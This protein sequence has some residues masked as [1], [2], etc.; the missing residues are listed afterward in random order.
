LYLSIHAKLRIGVEVEHQSSVGA[1]YVSGLVDAVQRAGVDRVELMRHAG[2]AADAHHA[3]VRMPM[4]DVI[5]LFQ[6]AVALTGRSDI[7]LEFARHVRP[8]TFNVLGYALMTCKTLGEAIAL[9]PHYRRLV[10][11][12]GY[13]EM[14]LVSTHDEVRLGWH[15]VSR[16]LPYC[17]SL[18]ES[19]IA[20][21]YQFGR[22]I[23]GV[24]LPL[25]EVRFLHSAPRD[26]R[27]YSEFFE[28]P[29]HFNARENALVFSRL[30]LDMPLV[31]ADETLHL[32]M[33]AQAQAAMEKTFSESD[34][35][36]RLRKA[37]I[38]LMPQCEATLEKAA[39]MLH[40]SPRSLQRRL[41]DVSLGFQGILD[42][43][44]RDM[45][46]IYLRDPGLSALD[47]ALLLGYAEQSSFTRAF[48]TWFG[49]NPRA[50][51][52]G[53]LQRSPSDSGALNIDLATSP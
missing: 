41:G 28:C 17:S 14:K 15:V 43:V 13:S 42:A 30:L 35:A 6:S 7:G 8:G 16:S 53:A 33:R 11:D 3:N 18:A 22:W 2:L 19:L 21:W 4:G 50:W 34:L 39:A 31:Q 37:L 1:G 32:A 23:A 38:A 36:H 25:V 45:A 44:R 40:M 10:F 9:V 46:V 27:A 49:M 24:G 26:V 51:R 20:S 12:I 52:T 29:V 47:V 48:R 5:A